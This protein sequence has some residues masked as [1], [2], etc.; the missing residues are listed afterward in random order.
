MLQNT[1]EAGGAS[2]AVKHAVLSPLPGQVA[3]IVTAWPP[4][5]LAGCTCGSL[6]DAVRPMASS[7]VES[8][9][10][11]L[12]RLVDPLKMSSLV[13]D[14]TQTEPKAEGPL[15]NV[16]RRP[17]PGQLE[18]IPPPTGE[19]CIFRKHWANLESGN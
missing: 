16:V 15:S 7:R 14:E 18:P 8:D 19:L 17:M 3:A 2:G 9:V 11:H 6:D 1:L 5:L 13:K 10:V 12:E 4:P